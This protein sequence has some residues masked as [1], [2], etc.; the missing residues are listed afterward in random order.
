MEY[1]AVLRKSAQDRNYGDK[2]SEMLCGRLVCASDLTFDKALK[3]A[4]AI[5][6][7]S[8]DVKDL[9]SLESAPSQG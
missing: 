7:T 1:V 5:K 8:K 2:L 9:K 4:P 3:V 6:T